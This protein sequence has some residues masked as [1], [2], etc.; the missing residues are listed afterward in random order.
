MDCRHPDSLIPMLTRKKVLL[1]I[2]HYVNGKVIT[3]VVFV[4]GSFCLFYE[5]TTL[6][7]LLQLR[8]IILNQ[9]DPK[10]ISGRF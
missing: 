2:V 1:F 10:V 3:S 4:S 9:D 8:G 5:I 6:P 7:F